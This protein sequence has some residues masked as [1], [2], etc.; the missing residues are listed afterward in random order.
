MLERIVLHAVFIATVLPCAMYPGV[1]MAGMMMLAAP[2]RDGT[3][4]WLVTAIKTFIYMSLAYPFVMGACWTGGI[5]RRG[6]YMATAYVA[7]CAGL[8][9]VWYF[10]TRNQNG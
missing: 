6:A 1:L 2:V 10:S 8:F 7:V 9:A 3:P 4:W 5:N